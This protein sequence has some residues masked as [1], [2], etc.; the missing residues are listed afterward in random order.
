M[1]RSPLRAIC[2]PS[3]KVSV[4]HVA[5]GSKAG[6]AVGFATMGLGGVAGVPCFGLTGGC[7]LT[8]GVYNGAC[9]CCGPC[10]L[11]GGV[12]NGACC[13]C[14]LG[15]GG[16]FCFGAGTNVTVGLGATGK[17]CGVGGTY[18]SG[19]AV[20]LGFGCDGGGV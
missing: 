11:A 7:G 2:L 4:P 16:V 5:F 6:C 14:G 10:V 9:G 18:G 13:G 20:G 19:G 1:S 15:F 3:L 12:Y 17:S 8:G